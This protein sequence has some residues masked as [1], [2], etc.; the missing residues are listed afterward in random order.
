[1]HVLR[2]H[3]NSPG[4]AGG[5]AAEG[6]CHPPYIKH[7]HYLPTKLNHQATHTAG[8]PAALQPGRR[9]SVSQTPPDGKTKILHMLSKKHIIIVT[10]PVWNFI[11]RSRHCNKKRS[12]SFPQFSLANTP[13]LGIAPHITAGLATTSVGQ[14]HLQ[15]APGPTIGRQPPKTKGRLAPAPQNPFRCSQGKF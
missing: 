2:T 5:S 15:V 8:K 6:A 9:D 13:F 1:I 4:D 14:P 3:S 11:A 10:L 7:Q 12:P